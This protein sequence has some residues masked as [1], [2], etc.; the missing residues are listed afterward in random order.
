MTWADEARARIA[1]NMVAYGFSPRERVVAWA[2]FTG[3]TNREIAE[4]QF[5]SVSTIKNCIWK[6]GRK[7]KAHNRFEIALRLLDVEDIVP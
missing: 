5:V 1:A 2:L 3:Q 4:E 6:M 7:V